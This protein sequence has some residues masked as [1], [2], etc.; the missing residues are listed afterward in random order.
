[1]SHEKNHCNSIVNRPTVFHF[2]TGLFQCTD[3]SEWSIF[4]DSGALAL[5]HFSRRD[6]FALVTT[7]L[8]TTFDCA[9]VRERKDDLTKHPSQTREF[10]VESSPVYIVQLLLKYKD[11]VCDVFQ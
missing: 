1:M 11:T 5:A 7:R 2:H 9:R 4:L 3:L 6:V 10:P 8:Y